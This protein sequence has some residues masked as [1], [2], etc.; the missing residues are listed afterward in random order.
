[1]VSLAVATSA[2][3]TECSVV[4]ALSATDTGSFVA[5]QVPVLDLDFGGVVG[6]RHY[7]IARPANIRQARYYPRGTMIRNRRQLTVVSVEEL[8]EVARRL[9]LLEVRAEWLGANLLVE[10][11]PRLSALPIGTRLLF[12]SGVGLVC[13]GVN[14]PCRLPGKVLQEHFPQSGAQSQFVRAAYGLRGI[15]ASVE[16]PGAIHS[17]DRAV[18]VPPEGYRSSANGLWS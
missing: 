10:G 9:E 15:A 3:A 11:I 4:Q 8:A 16:C 7:G 18:V 2:R 6:D 1:M 5:R 12:L 13:E 17:R 14:Q